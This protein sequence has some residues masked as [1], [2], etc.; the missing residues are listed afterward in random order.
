M[1]SSAAA[2][3]SLLNK[4]GMWWKLDDT[5]YIGQVAMNLAER[6]WHKLS[7]ILFD[8]KEHKDNVFGEVRDFFPVRGGVYLLSDY[9]LCFVPSDWESKAKTV[10]DLAQFEL[11]RLKKL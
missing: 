2:G 11:A 3:V 6:K 10:N 4:A 9:A 8:R 7:P 5:V 1:F